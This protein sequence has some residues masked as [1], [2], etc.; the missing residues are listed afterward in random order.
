M[1]QL[2][3]F[4]FNFIQ[5]KIFNLL[6]DNEHVKLDASM[7]LQKCISIVQKAVYA[8]KIS[9]KKKMQ[10]WI[11]D[12]RDMY[13]NEVQDN[14]IYR[15]CL[16]SDQ[17]ARVIVYSLYCINVCK[18]F[19]IEV[20]LTFDMACDEMSKII[21][22][23][24]ELVDGAPEQQPNQIRAKNWRKAIVCGLQFL[25][26]PVNCNDVDNVNRIS[27]T[28]LWRY[29]NNF[30]NYHLQL[31]QTSNNIEVEDIK[32]F[33]CKGNIFRQEFDEQSLSFNF[34]LELP[35]TRLDV[36]RMRDSTAKAVQCEKDLEAALTLFT[37]KYHLP[38]MERVVYDE[39]LLT[40]ID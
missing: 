22:E 38:L 30:V 35:I 33:F 15:G 6:L 21:G 36:Q 19:S 5:D 4:K 3:K 2:P 34:R 12:E 26:T 9:S 28:N 39:R 18:Q 8:K 24:V 27:V 40:G 31:Q 11:N 10:W 20:P 16:N 32:E 1:A 7:Y 29:M 17:A 23:Y 14:T 37:D 25:V 13:A